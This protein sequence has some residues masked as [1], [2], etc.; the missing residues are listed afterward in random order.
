[1]P[2]A[3]SRDAA[4]AWPVGV[5]FAGSGIHD[6]DPVLPIGVADQHGDGGAECFA[7]ANAGEELDAVGLDLHASSAPVALLAT[8][9]VD[10]DISGEQWKAG[11][12]AFEDRNERG[13]VRLAGGG[14]AEH[15]E[16]ENAKV[17]ERCGRLGECLGRG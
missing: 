4:F 13:S 7:G 6:L 17:A 9:E 2:R 16:I 15:W 3:H 11:R 12:D 8:C 5:A 14:E 10:V 1:M